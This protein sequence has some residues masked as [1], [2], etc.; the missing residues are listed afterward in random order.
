ML[1]IFVVGNLK[2][3]DHWENVGADG[4]IILDCI[5]RK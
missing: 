1:T 2:G 4:R 5:L 3:R